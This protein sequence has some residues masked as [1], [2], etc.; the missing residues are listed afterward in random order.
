MFNAFKAYS[1]SFN[2]ICCY[3]NIIAN[4]H[5]GK[6]VWILGLHLTIFSQ[7]ETQNMLFKI[8]WQICFFTLNIIYY[9]NS[10]VIITFHTVLVLHIGLSVYFLQF[11]ESLV[12]SDNILSCL[13]VFFDNL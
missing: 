5:C 9:N 13:E 1:W 2:F 10:D 12:K 6:V 7:I 11:E 8:F 3:N 4:R